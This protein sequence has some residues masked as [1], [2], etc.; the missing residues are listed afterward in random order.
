LSV[1][2]SE[3]DRVGQTQR[4]RSR[5]PFLSLLPLGAGAWAPIY[6]GVRARRWSWISLGVL[7]C[8]VALAGWTKSSFD[9]GRLSGS[10]DVAGLLM[11]VGWVGA[12]ATS[13]IIR[14]S[15]ERRMDSTLGRAE[16]AA[17][18]RI[19][20]SARAV[21]LAR[22]EPALAKEMG[23]GRPDRDGAFAAGVVDVNNAPASALE[24]LPGVDDALATSIIETRSKSGGFSSLEDLGLVLDLPGDLVEGLRGRVVFLPR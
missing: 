1:Q 15:Y 4:G 7:W 19:E 14:S 6:A 16:E 18:A 13:F 24:T 10:D 11:I 5:W 17:R 20:T 23:V 22:R 3:V 8:C 21:E 12:I 2:S 9:T